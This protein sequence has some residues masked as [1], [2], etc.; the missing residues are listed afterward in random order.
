MLMVSSETV[1]FDVYTLDLMRCAL[2]R[3]GETIGL[4]PKAFDVLRY[5]VE[6]EGRLVSKE[7][8][9]EAVWRG[10]SVTDDSVVQCVKDIREALS[11][12]NH[13]I[14][15][16]VPRRGYL[17]AARVGPLSIA[18]LPFADLS[19][20]SENSEY[21]GDGLA[22]ELINTL[23]QIPGLKVTSR[24]SSF[25]F[26]GKAQDIRSIGKVLNVSTILEGSV[27]RAGDQ[28][29]ITAQSPRGCRFGHGAILQNR[30]QGATPATP[31][32]TSS[33]SP[34]DIFGPSS[35]KTVSPRH[36]SAG[37]ARSRETQPIRFLMPAWP[38]RTTAP[39]CLAISIRGEH[40]K[41]S[42]PRRA[43]L[44][45]WTRHWRKPTFHWR[46]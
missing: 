22:E 45:S 16:T 6:H 3:G 13:R 24:S 26:R 29:R 9:V 38:T 42:N 19:G 30:R 41:R 33:I 39:I 35:P 18:V 23:T 20:D 32:P 40:L 25:R 17:F 46:I 34:A 12:D 4:R 15:Q 5:L 1:S 36:A 14:I 11:D 7:E 37:S 2:L 44:W 27:R 43:R 31:R 21:L 10:I 8:L 28:L